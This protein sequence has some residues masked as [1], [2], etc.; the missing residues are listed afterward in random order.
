MLYLL[1][2]SY[3]YI[4]APRYFPAA[5]TPLLYMYNTLPCIL[6]IILTNNQQYPLAYPPHPSTPGNFLTFSPSLL[7]TSNL[8]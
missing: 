4:Q 5:L 7:S 6:V 8:T 1:S 3:I 2:P